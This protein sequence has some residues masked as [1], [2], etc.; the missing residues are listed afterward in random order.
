MTKSLHLQSF[1]QDTWYIHIEPAFSSRQTVIQKAVNHPDLHWRQ[2]KHDIMM[3][4][5]IESSMDHSTLILCQCMFTYTCRDRWPWQHTRTEA[6]SFSL[7]VFHLSALFKN[8][9]YTIAWM[10]CLCLSAVVRLEAYLPWMCHL[11]TSH[12]VHWSPA[13]SLQEKEKYV[14]SVICET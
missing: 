6:Y 9:I 7:F 11:I 4:E 1:L 12:V 3:A 2:G 5:T 13:A 8:A 10:T 14:L